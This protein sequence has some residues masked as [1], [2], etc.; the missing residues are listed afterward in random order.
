MTVV[1]QNL[2]NL[3]ES[4]PKQVFTALKLFLKKSFHSASKYTGTIYR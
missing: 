2:L 1:H 4:Y 3:L